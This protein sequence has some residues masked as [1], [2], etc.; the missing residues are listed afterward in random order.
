MSRNNCYNY[1]SNLDETPLFVPSKTHWRSHLPRPPDESSILSTLYRINKNHKQEK[2]SASSRE[3]AENLN[4][5][6]LMEETE[7]DEN[8][9][10][11]LKNP[12]M[13]GEHTEFI[14]RLFFKSSD[15][16][17]I[18]SIIHLIIL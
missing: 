4:C 6:E 12:D 9:R 13:M 17:Y 14:A 7:S 5:P 10:S 3:P 1:S 2:K 11:A 16:D 18:I 8:R 15:K